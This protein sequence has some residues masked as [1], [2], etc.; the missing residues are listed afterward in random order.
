MGPQARLVEALD[1]PLYFPGHATILYY[2]VT[3]VSAGEIMLDAPHGIA[4]VS[5]ERVEKPVVGS[6][7][8]AFQDEMEF[9]GMGDY[10]HVYEEQMK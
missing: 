9:R 6:Y 10:T 5:F 7:A 4:Q 8:G 3:N 2:R 1:A